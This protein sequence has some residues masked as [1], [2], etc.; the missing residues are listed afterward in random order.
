MESKTF[1]R[2]AADYVKTFAWG[3]E[4][5]ESR[6]KKQHD[7]VVAQRA[8]ALRFLREQGAAARLDELAGDPPEITLLT[9]TIRADDEELGLA[10]VQAGASTT[11]IFAAP[12][13]A[14]EGPIH[15]FERP[16]TFA[17]RKGLATRAAALATP[18][19]LAMEAED[20]GRRKARIPGPTARFANVWATKERWIFIPLAGPAG[21][22][23]SCFG[24]PGVTVL[25]RGSPPAAVAD[26]L[27]ATI[28]RFSSVQPDA[29]GMNR[30]L[31]EQFAACGVK[32][33]SAI[34]AAVRKVSVSIDDEKLVLTRWIS[35]KNGFM[36]TTDVVSLENPFGAEQLVTAL[37]RMTTDRG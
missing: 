17:R 10:L 34:Y 25:E 26:E 18:E 29:A 6:R 23:G 31:K 32:K 11:R 1:E 5:P 16:M 35:E 9:F 2:W 7:K 37:D 15:V 13:R 8:E 22:P 36:P 30:L 14:D 21:A 19:A 20:E 27:R 33:E 28:D 4:A 24:I 3:G 12:S